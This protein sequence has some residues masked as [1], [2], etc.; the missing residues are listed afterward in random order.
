MKRWLFREAEGKPPKAW[1]D[2][3]SISPLLLELL[4][5]RGFTQFDEME[6]FLSPLLCRL[7]RPASW[8]GLDD[9]AALLAGELL[10]GKK[11]AVWGDY[12]VDGV[13]ATALVLDVLACHAMTA[14]YHLPDRRTEG[15]GLNVEGIEALAAAGC[16]ALLTVDCGIS[17]VSAVT[18]ARELGMTV[19]ISDHHLPPA[20]L[21]P[22]HAVCNPRLG[23]SPCPAL[24]GVGVAFYLMAAV[25]AALAPHTGK[26]YKMD[27]ALDLVALGTIADV[28]RL[29]GENRILVR[30]G[31]DA[32][33]L[34]AR[35][36][37]AALK[38]VSD[39]DS[40]AY[41][42]SGQVGFRLT[43][44][45]NA[46]GR[47]GS[48][49][50]ALKLLRERSHAAARVLASE[51]D[52]LNRQRKNAEDIFVAEARSQA[53]ALL[54]EKKRAALVLHGRNWNSG[55]AG[56][57]A[58]RIVDEFNRPTV[59][60]CDEQGFLKGSGRSVQDFDLHAA[61]SGLACPLRGFGG[62]RMAAGVRL[63]PEYLAQFRES[64]E[65]CAA[66]I[67]GTS[68]GL[69]SLFLECE[70]PLN[71]AAEHCFLK[72]LELMQP[73]GPGNSEPVFAS[74][75]LLVK[76]RNFLGNGREHVQL[77]VQDESG[78][79]ITAKAWRMAESIPESLVGQK[80]RLA[81]TTRLD[82][83]SGMASVELLVKDWSPA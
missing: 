15:Y 66:E 5:R 73:F 27:A 45:I 82:R 44:R 1:A 34:A 23:E 51:L 43:P 25:N 14:E 18:R 13:A 39:S 24:A 36:G 31:L 74:P 9:T 3:L 60:F 67:L 26:R 33:A 55:I 77:K 32:L 17:D 65:A 75:P 2:K 63:A 56:I 59:I 40:A 22:A 48:A 29:V 79:T 80:I 81:Y 42:T 68:P 10:A 62:H 19:I 20:R 46:A 6:A 8:P 69:P 52:A 47:M 61:L 28:M 7:P 41:L 21:P 30:A 38:A 58:S 16:A 11:L 72:E 37:V 53:V 76:A 49:T 71:R 35:P 64:F 57:V 70:L 83:F 50:L 54:R 4:W 12:D 78:L